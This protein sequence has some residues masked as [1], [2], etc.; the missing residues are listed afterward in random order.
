MK[1]KTQVLKRISS[2]TL[3]TAL[4]IFMSVC[5]SL[6]VKLLGPVTL[7]QMKLSEYLKCLIEMTINTFLKTPTLLALCL[8]ISK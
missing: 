6:V 4:A 2:R 3:V 1:L 7:Q 8:K 5:N